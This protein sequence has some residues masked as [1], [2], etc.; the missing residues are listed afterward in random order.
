MLD[1]S[2]SKA[3]ILEF[4]EQQVVEEDLP[5]M[6]ECFDSMSAKDLKHIDYL[7]YLMSQYPTAAP[8]LLQSIFE[9]LREDETHFNDLMRNFL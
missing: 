1:D 8:H 6:R 2:N 5:K 3:E 4:L 7:I 9:M